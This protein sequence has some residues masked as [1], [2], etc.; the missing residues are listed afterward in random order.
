M[1]APPLACAAR[2]AFEEEIAH[3]RHVQ[4]VSTTLGEF[5]RMGARRRD[6]ELARDRHIDQ[7]NRDRMR[8]HESC[9][10]GW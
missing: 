1:T 2:Q 10:C 9:P 4:E 6:A 8:G 7:A 5:H 3:C